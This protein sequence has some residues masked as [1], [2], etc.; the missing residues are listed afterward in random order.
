MGHI[1]Q[2]RSPALPGSLRRLQ[3]FLQVLP[4]E[5]LIAAAGRLF[6]EHVLQTVEQILGANRQ[7]RDP[8]AKSRVTEQHLEQMLH[9]QLLVAP[10]A[11][12]ILSGEQ[13]IPGFIAE[14]IGLMREAA[15][16][17]GGSRHSAQVSAREESSINSTL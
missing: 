15:P 5:Q 8:A 1:D 10:A 11:G 16:S 13:Q 17:G 9:I 3:Q 14:A 4:D 6:S 7:R 2:S 12:H